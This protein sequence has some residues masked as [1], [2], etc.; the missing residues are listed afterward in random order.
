M[1]LA[2]HRYG[3]AGNVDPMVRIDGAIF[4]VGGCI[5]FIPD[6]HSPGAFN[7]HR[8][9]SLGLAQ[10]SFQADGATTGFDVQAGVGQVGFFDEAYGGA[11]AHG[12]IVPFAGGTIA[13]R[14]EGRTVVRLLTGLTPVF[15][16]IPVGIPINGF[17][18]NSVLPVGTSIA[19][20][21]GSLAVICFPFRASYPVH[22][23][24]IGGIVGHAVKGIRIELVVSAAVGTGFVQYAGSPAA[25]PENLL[26]V[27]C[28]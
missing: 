27:R 7:V 14:Q 9:E 21:L 1:D 16:G 3:A 4:V 8:I 25:G 26:P 19:V 24:L 22:A 2:A 11:P 23:V 5:G 20:E 18:I 6:G 10:V 15:I 13:Y 28:G 17:P 12:R